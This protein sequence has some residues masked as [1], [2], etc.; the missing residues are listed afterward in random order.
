MRQ[1]DA[2]LAHLKRTG[3][4]TA[5]DALN[6]YGVFRLAARNRELRER[7][8]KITTHRVKTRGGKT[9]ARYVRA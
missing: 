1:A 5:I 3:P 7:G 4:I 6:K 2:I 8:E 9:I